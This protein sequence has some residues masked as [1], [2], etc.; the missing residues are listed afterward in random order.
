MA[1]SGGW[2]GDD[3]DGADGLSSARNRLAQSAG[4]LAPD[5]DW[6]GFSL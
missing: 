1:V 2:G 3:L 6:L 4:N 5:A